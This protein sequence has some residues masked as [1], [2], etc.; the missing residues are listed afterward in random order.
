MAAQTRKSGLTIEIH[1]GAAMRPAVRIRRARLGELPSA[2]LP[3][4]GKRR[5]TA[6]PASPMTE[7]EAVVNAMESQDLDLVDAI[8]LSLGASTPAATSRRRGGEV[9]PAATAGDV[10]LAVPL[11]AG[12]SAVVLVSQD[13]V[14]Q[15]KL[16]DTEGPAPPAAPPSRRGARVSRAATA[17]ERTQVFRIALRPAAPTAVALGSGRRRG[18]L[19]KLGVGKVMVYVFRFLAKPVLQGVAKFMERHVKQGL[20]H[21]TAPDPQTWVTL[22]DDTPVPVP[23]GRAARVLMLVHG[24]FSSTVGSFGALA[25][26]PEGRAFLEAALRSYDL[27]I[28]WDHRTLGELP[29]DNAIALAARLERIGFIEPPLVDAVCFSRGGLVLRSLIEQV[30]PSSPLK[31]VVRRAVFVGATNG[32]TELAN[33]KNWHRLADRYTNLAA[34]GARGAALVPGFASTGAILAA[35]ISGVGVLVKVIASATVTDGAVPGLAAMDPEGDFV[36][37]INGPQPGQPTPEQTY[38]CAITS[39]FDPDTARAQMDSE[40]MP[41]GLLLTLADKATDALYG[42]PNDLV[43]HVESMTQIYEAVG[44][45]IRERF[46]FGTNGKVHHCAYFSQ[47]ETAERLFTWLGMMPGEGAARAVV[48]AGITPRAVPQVIRLRSTQPVDVAL[49]RVQAGRQPWIVIERPYMEGDKP[50]TYRYAHPTRLGQEWLQEMLTVPGAT[51]HEAFEL[52][53]MLRSPETAVGAAV[54]GIPPQPM[55]SPQDLKQKWG[56]QFRTIE[57]EQ[58]EAVNVIAP[59][60][61]ELPKM[62]IPKMAAAPAPEPTPTGAARRRGGGVR[63]VPPPP[64]KKAAKKPAAKK[65][66]AKGPLAKKPRAKKAAAKKAP[67][68]RMAAKHLAPNVAAATEEVACHFRAETD[69]EYVLEQAHT[70]EV[71]IS[72]EALRAAGR[73]VSKTGSAKVKTTKPLV[74]ECMPMLRVSL[75]NPTDARVEIPVPAPGAPTE[76]RFDLKGNEVGSAQVRV[77]VRQGPLPLVTLTLDFSVI[78]ARSGTRRPVTAAADLAEFPAIP[79]ATDELRIWQRQPMGEKTQYTYELNL[80]S[81]RV[82]KAF[83]SPLLDSA[84]AKYVASIHKRIEDRWAQ[85]RSEKEAFARDLRAIGG[86]L[87]DELFPLELKQLLWQHRQTIRS[88][89]VLSSEPF[90]PWELVFLRNPAQRKPGPDAAFLGELGVVRWLVNGYPPE[91][92]R[93]RKNKARYVIPDYPAPNELPDAQ[94][95]IDMLKKRFGATEVPAEAEAVYDLLEQA[96]NFDLLH[97]ACHGAADAADIGTARLE[98]PGKQRMDGSLSEEDVLAT[99]VRQE[100]ELRA[101]GMQPI[102]VLNACQSARSGYT[103]KGMGGFAEAFIEAGAGVF[104]G[105][106]WSVGDTPAFAFMDEFYAQLVDERKPLATAAAAARK[107]AREDGDATWL[108]YVVYGH[109][110]AKVTS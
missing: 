63:A 49:A 30:M 25:G 2:Q 85:H 34:A 16:A 82:R 65:A 88:V 15:W 5:A 110:R 93:I 33:P 62:A 18:L 69:D 53:E 61:I 48:R 96:G 109:P 83:E 95:E 71:I 91:A 89:Q 103:L 73:S 7:E 45:Y 36:R 104:V 22:P 108:A 101:D 76:L 64:A 100:A 23:S 19:T 46:D 10:D 70:V 4:K 50:V 105:S 94:K 55:P 3:V 43:V 8:R 37:D 17:P 78:E 66:A 40:V 29:S 106:S 57:I 14:Y 11:T 60:E 68:K 20:V 31:L 92:L 67:A 39:N 99:T 12:E 32:G 6:A 1:G 75:Q 97:F 24:T 21:I 74:V 54:S 41:P 44:S 58:G 59:D 86:E 80:A 79:L 9:A 81:V 77:Q 90:I 87:F 35:A 107:K 42:K 72:R 52:R 51:V 98:M 56:S 47:R 27:V 102:V 13:G 38:Y 84:P 26:Q 28:G